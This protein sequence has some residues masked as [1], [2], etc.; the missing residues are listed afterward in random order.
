MVTQSLSCSLVGLWEPVDC[1]V[2][3]CGGLWATS[4]RWKQKIYLHLSSNKHIMRKNTGTEWSSLLCKSF[5]YTSLFSSEP[6]GE[7]KTNCTITCL[8]SS[9]T[10][11]VPP[12]GSSPTPPAGWRRCCPLALSGS[13]CGSR[14]Q[15]APPAPPRSLMRKQSRQKSLEWSCGSQ[16]AEGGWQIH[17]RWTVMSHMKSHDEESKSVYDDWDGF[18]RSR[19]V[20]V[21]ETWHWLK[22]WADLSPADVI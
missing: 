18:A 11:A 9:R 7:T 17:T 3:T 14:L 20:T 4:R 10:Q 2:P 15:S 5:F 21:N 1:G 19:S 8:Y 16:R 12:G 13:P 22:R 6:R